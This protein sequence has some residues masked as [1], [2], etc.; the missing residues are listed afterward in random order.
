MSP[1]LSSCFQGLPDLQEAD[2]VV[3]TVH[4]AKGLE[5][6]TVV[7]CDDYAKTLVRKIGKVLL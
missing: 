1:K 3:S 7:L 5:F 2:T 4:K 6:D